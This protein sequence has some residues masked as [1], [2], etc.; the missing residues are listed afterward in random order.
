MSDN[1]SE[2]ITEDKRGGV[3]PRDV[4]VSIRG[5]APVRGCLVSRGTERKR[6]SGSAVAHLGAEA[7]GDPGS[8]VPAYPS[9][10]QLATCKA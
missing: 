4:L 6:V 2:E 3:G 10:L 9:L 8:T 1:D 7:D 5:S